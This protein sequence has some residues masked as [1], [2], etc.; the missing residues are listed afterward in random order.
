MNGA[1]ESFGM[2]D[3]RVI[4][5]ERTY[6]KK[7]RILHGVHCGIG[8]RPATIAF[9]QSCQPDITWESERFEK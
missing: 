5:P 7:P 4:A 2:E 9:K 8:F 6:W 1:L 3:T